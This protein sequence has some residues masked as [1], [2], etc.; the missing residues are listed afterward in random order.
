MALVAKKL[1][2]TGEW[3]KEQPELISGKNSAMTLLEK[4]KAEKDA[5]N[6]RPKEKG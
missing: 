1:D 3:R 2:V 5:L 4:I 6:N